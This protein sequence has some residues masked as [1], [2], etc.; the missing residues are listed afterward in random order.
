MLKIKVF[1]VNPLGEN[2]YILSNNENEGI[3]IDCGAKEKEECTMIKAYLE[4]EKITLRYVLLTHGHFDH[5]LGLPFLKNEYDLSP[6]MH[7]NDQ[8]WYDHCNE[9][10]ISVFNEGLKEPMPTIGCY[11]EDGQTIQLGNDSFKVI[12]TPGHTQGGVCFYN[13]EQ[14]ILFS[15]DTL[16]QCSVGRSDLEG[17][18]QSQLIKAICE[19]LLVLPDHVQVYPGHGAPT[20]IGFEKVNNYYLV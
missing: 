20:T 5:I 6:M 16:F 17:G 8:D 15:G 9:V 3:I 2:C 10:C 19:K 13:E 11:L 12:H 4:Q 14:G 1:R 18:N 7:I